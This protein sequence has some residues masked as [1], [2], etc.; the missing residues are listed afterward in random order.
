MNNEGSFIEL[1]Q[2]CG[3]ISMHISCIIDKHHLFNNDTIYILIL[4]YIIII[5]L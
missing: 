2:N 4:Q 1:V 3:T 5:K